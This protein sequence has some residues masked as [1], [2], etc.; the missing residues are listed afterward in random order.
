MKNLISTFLK[1][2]VIFFIAKEIIGLE[3]LVCT[4][5]S[6]FLFSFLEVVL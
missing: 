3:F 6:F 2:H 5:E 4:W 1:F